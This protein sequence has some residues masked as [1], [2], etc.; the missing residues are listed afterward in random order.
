MGHAEISGKEVRIREQEEASKR[1][2]TPFVSHNEPPNIWLVRR[3]SLG[4][5]KRKG[6]PSPTAAIR[7]GDETRYVGCKQLTRISVGACSERA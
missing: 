4:C 3:I 2:N 5:W 6:H 1:R 7:A